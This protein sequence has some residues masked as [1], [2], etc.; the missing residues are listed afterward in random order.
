MISDLAGL[1]Q[2]VAFTFLLSFFGMAAGSLFFLIERD[3][4]AEEFRQSV[5][6]AGVVCAIAALNYFYMRGIY[7]DGLETGDSRFPTEF[8]Y[9]DWILTV[10]LMIVKFPS[11]LGLGARGRQVILTLVG[12]ALV[13]IV[14][15]YIGEVNGDNTPIHI[16]FWVVG[17]IAGAA[18]IGLLAV[19]MREL[20][21]H[22]HPEVR[23][24]IRWMAAL[25][26]FGWLVYPL[27]YLAPD[28]GLAPDVRE[29]VY[30]VADVVNKVGLGLIVYFG[31]R[32]LWKAQHATQAGSAP[33]TAG[34]GAATPAA[35]IDTPVGAPFT[36][37][38]SAATLPAEP[39]PTA[40]AP[41]DQP[42]AWT[43]RS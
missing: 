26:L 43:T 8:R 30:N 24:T 39:A 23:T 40:G 4:V 33:A 37:P 10:P 6:I 16:G 14:T 31:G 22:V 3:R 28:L 19:A 1:Q 27:G 34:V 29:L 21:A 11:L 18:I 5:V 20:P 7:I 36:S 2:L 38:P 42:R 15:G 25:V 35:P 17:C 13:M 41:V 12:L 9:I 32:R